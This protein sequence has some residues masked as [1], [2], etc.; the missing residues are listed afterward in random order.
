[1][2]PGR[3]SCQGTFFQF[4]RGYRYRKKDQASTTWVP[5]LDNSLIHH[6]GRPF[7]GAAYH[8]FIHTA[9]L[10]VRHYLCRPPST[11]A[12]STGSLKITNGGILPTPSIYTSVSIA[13]VL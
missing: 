10:R 11:R 1:G 7:G 3:P 12:G 8:S 5:G 4:C 13:P 2:V 6:R 9:A